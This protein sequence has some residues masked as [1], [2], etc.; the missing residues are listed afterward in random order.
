MPSSLRRL[1]FGTLRRQLIFGVAAVHAVMMTLFVA[2]LTLRQQR[3]FRERQREHA[4]ALTSAM[5]VSS[6][7]WLAARDISGLQEIVRAQQRYPELEFAMLLDEHGQVLA[8]TDPRR[9]GLYVA[10]LPAQ[11]AEADLGEGQILVDFTAP[12]LVGGRH[13]GWARVGV[14]QRAAT[15]TLARMAMDGALYAGA[16]ILLG[17][18]M[19]W[20]MA[21]RLTR[22]LHRI[23]RAM[24]GVAA[25][26]LAT[27]VPISGEDEAAG[28]A[29]GFNGMIQ[30]LQA[31]QEERDLAELARSES[32]SRFHSLIDQV[33]LPLVVLQDLKVHYC[34]PAGA[35]LFRAP[36]PGELT[37]RPIQ[38]LIPPEDWPLVQE[39]FGAAL[40]A[41]RVVDRTP[42]RFLALDGTPLEV[43][44]QGFPVQFG[45]KASLLLFIEDAAER[46]RL[47]RMRQ[48]LERELR[49]AQKM[50]SLGSLAGGVAHD[51][52]N[53]LAAIL[54]LAT[55]HAQHSPEGSS[56]KRALETI[57]KACQR[58][59]T[60]V[61]GLLGFARKEL[62]QQVPVDLN[63]V[64]Q[65]EVALLERTTLQRIRLVKDLAPDLR[66][67]RGDPG[68]LSHALM[69][70]CVNAVDA[71]PEGGTLLLRTR[72]QGA[73]GV[74]LEVEDS[75]MGMT[76]EV[77]ERALDPFFT[78]KPQ[79]KGT[80]LGLPMVY[81]T[82][83]AHGGRLEIASTPGQGTR[84]TLRLPAK[85]IGTGN[86]SGPGGAAGP[87][88]APS[89]GILLVDDDE[90]VRAS[91]GAILQ[92]LGHRPVL[93]SSGEE[94]LEVLGSGAAFDFVILDLNMPGLG[95][96]A[97]L[98]RIRETRPELPVLLATGRADQGASALVE[99]YPGVSLLPKPFTVQDLQIR[100][101]G[102][103]LPRSKA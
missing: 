80:G 58:G 62:S 73:D 84:V 65:E 43:E 102:G 18:L 8:H 59:A 2:D 75:G 26:D 57:T 86:D 56:L 83:K 98:G 70:L 85:A 29:E 55:L 17:S 30:A 19:A 4:R 101:P 31:R 23:Q 67:V 49:Q 41:G 15:G 10:D 74:L 76:P 93:A 53:V 7:G 34:N 11:P 95:G 32:E 51:M 36:G 97:T 16:A 47:D 50:D 66:Q 6:A 54:G 91:M 13:V 42:G 33:P 1:F 38:D 90:L 92:A 35:R 94:A 28:L 3:L 64:V 9:I 99:H 46:N 100:L 48:H 14:G 103:T 69:N 24:D 20:V 87:S 63:A 37:G 12:A 22:R 77:Q 44:T 71:M 96:A 60:L 72:N 25:G 21:R 81:G 45:G 39:R 79:G 40:E 88:P 78:T 27:R 82:V 52:N 61:K 5:A 89:C 68:A